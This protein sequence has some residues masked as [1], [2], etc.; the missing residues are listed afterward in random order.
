MPKGKGKMKADTMTKEGNQSPNMSEP[1]EPDYF[2]LEV[3][4]MDIYSVSETL[5][6]FFND[7]HDLQETEEKRNI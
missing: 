1:I 3:R 5:S 7:R 2:E 4:D 6:R